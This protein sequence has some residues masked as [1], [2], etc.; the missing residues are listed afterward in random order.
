MPWDLFIAARLIAQVAPQASPDPD[1]GRAVFQICSACHNGRADA[2]GPSL[3]GV[4]GRTAGTLEGFRYSN[5]MK[6]AGFVWDVD[7]L[8]SFVRDPQAVVPG[9]RMPFSGLTQPDDVDDLVFYLTR[10]K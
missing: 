4:L 5:P 10:L 7:R 2:L 1:H 3:Q 9:T 6:R 8:K